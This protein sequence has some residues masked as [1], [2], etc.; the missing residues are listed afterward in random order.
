MTTWAL[1]VVLASACLKP[2]DPMPAPA[3]G[4]S[5]GGAAAA[6]PTLELSP[7]TLTVPLGATAPLRVLS[8]QPDGTT[9]DVTATAEVR[10]EPEG[11]VT[12]TRGVVRAI[13]AGSALLVAKSGA[14]EAR[15]SVTVPA[16]QVQTVDVLTAEPS[17][18]KGALVEATA[19]ATLTDGTRL[20]VTAAATWSVDNPQDVPLVLELT[21]PGRFLARAPGEA[22][23]KATVGVASGAAT[24]TVRDSRL[25]SLSVMPGM[26]SVPVNGAAQ[27]TALARFA[28]GS[29]VDVTRSA[30][31][32]SSAPTFAVDARG[33]ALAKSPGAATI[34]AE[35]DG[36]SGTAM[37][38]ATEATARQLAF[39]P[40]SLTVGVRASAAFHLVA[41]FSDGSTLDVTSQASFS[42]GSAA[43]AAVS[44]TEPRGVVTGLSAGSATITARFQ[45]LSATAPVTVTAAAVQALELTPRTFTIAGPGAI[46]VRARAT[47]ADGSQADVTEQALWATDDATVAQVSNVVGSRGQVRGLGGGATIVRAELAGVRG[48]ADVTVQAAT[49]VSLEVAPAM[50]SVEAGRSTQLRALA[51][52]SDNSTRDVTQQAT[53]TSLTPQV[54]TVSTTAGARGQVRG[55]VNGVATIQASL[56]GQ[57]A[58]GTVRVQPPALVQLSISPGALSVPLGLPAGF[59]AVAAWSD[60]SA[61]PVTDQVQ[62]TSSNP[63]VAEVLLSQG[64]AYLDSKQAGVTVITATMAGVAPAQTTVT[65]TSATLTRLDV[66]P[67]R[68]VLPVGAYVELDAS[69]I[70]SDL[71]TQYL[72]YASSWTSSEPSVATVGNGYQDKGFVTALRPGTTTIT[73]TFNGVSSST[74]LTVSAATLQQ[75]QVTPFAPRLPIGFDTTL[76]ATGLYSDNS[77]RDLTY[78]VSWTSSAPAVAT[79]GTYAY[80]QPLQA[81][82]ATITATYGATQGTTVVTVTGATLTGITLTNP[83]STALAVQET[84]ALTARGSFSDGTALDVTP[85][86]TWLSSAPAIASVSNAWPSNGEVKGLSAGAATITAVRGTVSAATSV[87]VQ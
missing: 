83:A 87:Q 51:W 40:G 6:Q 53:W 73:A 23:V 76:R 68:P 47:Y 72:R 52:F 14:L 60:G 84:R 1:L 78:L 3:G 48:Q 32:S 34:T 55:L 54:A 66:T 31:W 12:V 37:L 22:R 70:Y 56:Q 7:A 39:M 19:L 21:G 46:S 43:V 63:A 20:D 45:G 59:E 4:G 29:E 30:V 81:G 42:S 79:V 62:W 33:L 26:A 11:V 27:L 38:T 50:V 41:T 71:T 18:L 24:M 85:Y 17:V 25:L 57:T 9:A 35:L 77:T 2:V 67:A 65:V 36:Q 44:T 69:G 82:T 13:A 5:A 15:A 75:L 8:I 28:D 86:V 74:V 64:Y 16:A 61:A 80:L 49:L 10:S 58:S